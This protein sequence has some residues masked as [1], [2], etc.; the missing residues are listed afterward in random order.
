ML[1][2]D[3]M[4]REYDVENPCNSFGIITCL[5]KKKQIADALCN[6]ICLPSKINFYGNKIM[7]HGS[8]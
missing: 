6:L 2:Q 1:R 5:T 3:T 8:C 7:L 4:K